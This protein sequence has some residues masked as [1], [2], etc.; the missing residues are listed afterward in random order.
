MIAQAGYRPLPAYRR[1]VAEVVA[2]LGADAQRG[3]E[4]GAVAERL[5]RYGRNE[6]PAPTKVPAWR[7]FLAQFRNTLTILLLVATFVSL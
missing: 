3:L 6:L 2:A 1:P 7:H 4:P 5:G